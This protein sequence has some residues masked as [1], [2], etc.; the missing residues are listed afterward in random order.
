[1]EGSPL[2]FVDGGADRHMRPL[3]SDTQPALAAWAKST[4]AVLGLG[5][6]SPDIVDIHRTLLHF[7]EGGENLPALYRC[8]NAQRTGAVIETASDE[9]AGR[10]EEERWAVREDCSLSSA[11]SSPAPRG[12]PWRGLGGTR[13]VAER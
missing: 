3:A 12:V 4:D 5:G 9:I 7:T 13:D 6:K 1:L 10:G 11:S 2:K 8:R